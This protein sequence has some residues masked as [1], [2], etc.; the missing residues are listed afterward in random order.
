MPKCLSPLRVAGPSL[1]TV[2]TVS[3]VSV[4]SGLKLQVNSPVLNNQ[5]GILSGMK[6][7]MYRAILAKRNLDDVSVP[8]PVPA[9][10]VVPKAGL[11]HE[12]LPHRIAPLLAATTINVGSNV[13]TCCPPPPYPLTA[14]ISLVPG[15]SLM[16]VARVGDMLSYLAGA[17]FP[18]FNSTIQSFRNDF[19]AATNE[20]YGLL[21]LSRSRWSYSV[22]LMQSAFI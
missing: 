11:I 4:A 18:L 7:A 6:G 3:S 19:D 5:S 9:S 10:V 13:S 20:I 12:V 17:N 21:P 16:D 15:G 22:A 14:R 8:L 2:I 1:T